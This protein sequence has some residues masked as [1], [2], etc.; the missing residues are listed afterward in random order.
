M[1]YG[2]CKRYGFSLTNWMRKH[3]TFKSGWIEL[4]IPLV[5]GDW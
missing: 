2:Q 5:K 1:K 4:G 3:T